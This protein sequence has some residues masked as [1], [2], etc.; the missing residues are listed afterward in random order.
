M[1][2][3]TRVKIAKL[4]RGGI[5]KTA[6]ELNVVFT[7]LIIQYLRRKELSYQTCNDIVGSFR[8]AEDEFKKKVVSRFRATPWTVRGALRYFEELIEDIFQFIGV[9]PKDGPLFNDPDELRQHL[10]VQAYRYLKK[11]GTTKQT[12]KDV[13]GALDNA[14]DEFRR[15][16]QHP[17]E[18]RKIRENGDIYP[19][20]LAPK[21]FDLKEIDQLLETTFG[22]NAH[23]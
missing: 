12:I 11:N 19:S 9:I 15:R 5:P 10:M 18:N 3:L 6:G 13:R 17:Y 22:G 20:D 7:T 23:S 2:Y 8:E 4:Q 21:I 16:V 14:L 1:P